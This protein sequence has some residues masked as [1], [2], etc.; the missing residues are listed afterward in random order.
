[1]A[2]W[3]QIAAATPKTT[4]AAAFYLSP[5]I[6]GPDTAKTITGAAHGL[7]TPGL[8]VAVYDNASPRNAIEMGWTV[9]AS[10]FDVVVTFAVAQSDYYILIK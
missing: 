2:K 10:T 8:L 4:P 5:L 9:D 6:T 7:A 3:I 1:M